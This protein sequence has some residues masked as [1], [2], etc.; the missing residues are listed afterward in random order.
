MW[1]WPPPFGE[2]AWG[3]VFSYTLQTFCVKNLALGLLDNI[4]P[5]EDPT[6][7][8]YA[9]HQW[10]PVESVIGQSTLVMDRDYMLYIPPGLRGKDLKDP[11]LRLLHHLTRKRAAIDIRD[12]E[13]M[14]QRTIVEFRDLYGA[15]STYFRDDLSEGKSGTLM[16]FM[17]TRFVTKFISF[18][19]RITG[20]IGYTGGESLEQIILS[21]DVLS[22]PIQSYAP[23][24]LA[25]RPS[26]VGDEAGLWDVLPEEVK[27]Q[28]AR[29]IES[30]PN[31]QRP[32]LMAWL[33]EKGKGQEEPLSIGDLTDLGFDPTRLKEITLR[34]EEYIFE[35]IQVR[36][37]P[38][39]EKKKD[40]LN[41]VTSEMGHVRSRN[42]N[43]K[44]NRPLLVIQDRGNAYVLRRK[45]S[46]IHWEEAL[47]QVQV[48]QG[49]KAMNAL[50]RLDRLIVSTVR[51]ANTLISNGLNDGRALP[52][53]IHGLFCLM[54]PQDQLSGRDGG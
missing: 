51:E 4:I 8:I 17:F 40:L 10:V 46:G 26:L 48:T 34:G 44:V 9:K 30:L 39:L 6:N 13:L 28:P 43:L 11:V 54:G 2:K 41:R 33:K 27:R 12:N 5:E 35:R 37:L 20:L 53:E 52:P 50:T 24:E 14:V 15:L 31:Y 36:Q 25:D 3:T 23:Q 1:R 42:A 18:R 19:R 47:E 21:P 22:L 32:T 29:L 49:L 16:R 7:D 38:D 45:I